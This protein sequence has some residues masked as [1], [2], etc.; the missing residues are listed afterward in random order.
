M[1]FRK[2]ITGLPGL[3]IALQIGCA[4]SGEPSIEEFVSSAAS[5]ASHAEIAVYYREKATEMRE[6]SAKHSRLAEIYGGDWVWG[7]TSSDYESSRYEELAKNQEQM[8]IE[9]EHLAAEHEKLAGG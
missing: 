9:Y 8:A 1:R 4:S 7:F 5:P 6:L 2:T 3:F